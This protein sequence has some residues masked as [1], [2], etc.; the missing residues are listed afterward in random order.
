MSEHTIDGGHFVA[1]NQQGDPEKLKYLH[2]ANWQPK[3]LMVGGRGSLAVDSRA[4]PGCMFPDA[5][6]GK[7]PHTDDARCRMFPARVIT[8]MFREGVAEVRGGKLQ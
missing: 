6:P 7:W 4:C 1:G 2:N 5:K 3:S 8:K